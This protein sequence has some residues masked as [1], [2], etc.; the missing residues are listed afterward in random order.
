MAGL[1]WTGVACYLLLLL[2]PA[3]DPRRQVRWDQKPLPSARLGLAVVCA[4][5][6]LVQARALGDGRADEARQIDV[7]VSVVL[8]GVLGNAM[9]ALRPNWFFGIRTPWT[10]RD[11][12]VWDRTHRVAGHALVGAS[13]L[14]AG[15]W[16][17]LGSAAFGVAFATVMGGLLAFAVLYSW[18]LSRKMR[19]PKGS[20]P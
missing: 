7:L 16:A 13:I 14:L 5:G 1:A 17:V 4:I 18:A 3:V 10:L 19:S 11:D 8:L 20:A 12:R 2:G 9:P 6:A 15:L